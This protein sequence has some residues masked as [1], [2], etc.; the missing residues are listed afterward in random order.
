MKM[1]DV[2]IERKYSRL[3]SNTGNA[4]LSRIEAKAAW[5]MMYDEENEQFREL[6]LKYYDQ[7]RTNQMTLDAKEEAQ[8]LADKRRAQQ[9]PRQTR[10]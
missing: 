3:P 8:R 4:Q 9:L 6:I 5:K 2:L 7:I 10:P 1:K